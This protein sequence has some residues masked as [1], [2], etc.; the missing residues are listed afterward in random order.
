LQ[1]AGTTPVIFKAIC[2]AASD[3]TLSLLSRGCQPEQI[4]ITNGTQQG[5]DLIG[6]LLMEADDTMAMKILAI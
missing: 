3:R 6:R 2:P 1:L 5:L 4:V